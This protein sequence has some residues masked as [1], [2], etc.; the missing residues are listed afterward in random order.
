[1]INTSRFIFAAL[2]LLLTPI[3][4]SAQTH[5][6]QAKVIVDSLASPYFG[7]RGYG[8]NQ[9]SLAADYIASLFES[10]NLSPLLDTYFQEFWFRVTIHDG[11]PSLSINGKPLRLGIDFLPIDSRTPSLSLQNHTEFVYAGS[12]VVAPDQSINEYENKDI[13]QKV[14][15]LNDE[16]ADS[17]RNNPNILPQ[18]LS[19]NFR[20]Q[21]AQSIGGAYAVLF[22][23]QSPMIYG[24]RGDQPATWTPGLAVHQDAWPDEFHSVDI[25]IESR[26]QVPIS[27]TNVIGYQ[28]GTRF[29]DKYIVIIGHYDHLGRLGPNHYF[30]GANDNASGIALMAN[31][32]THFKD[33]PLPYS[34]LY[35]AFSGEE[36]GLLGSNY[37]VE[38]TPIA[39]DSIR[40]LINLDMV[41]S[42]SG[43]MVAL[44]GHDSPEEYELLKTINDSLELGPLRK[45]S[46]APNSDH[47]FFLEKGVPGFFLY[48]DK[49]TQPYHHMNDVPETLDWDEFDDTFQLVRR[50]IHALSHQDK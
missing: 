14:V 11:T 20:S 44:G 21:I 3:H 35:I 49:G 16:V 40:F 25:K 39:L 28:K 27:T 42:G 37:F 36:K 6:Q 2:L 43:G 9:D 18:F 23:T 50:F 12:G 22:K 17:L 45:R 1:M 31:I 46:N 32:A 38:N 41:A 10:A 19:R 48:T 34:L 29:P 47:Y 33:T 30:P 8:V 26:Q 5:I 7:G 24:R 15:L 4:S 13:L